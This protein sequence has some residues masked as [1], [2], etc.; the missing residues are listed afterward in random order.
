MGHVQYL[1]V[2]VIT[3]GYFLVKHEQPQSLQ[4]AQLLRSKPY[5][6]PPETWHVQLKS[7]RNV[8]VS[9][10]I[11]GKPKQLYMDVGQNGRPRGP[12]MLV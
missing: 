11:L 8:L 1:K 9:P 2:L 12:Q 10:P 7:P 4:L 3:R 5:R 6:L